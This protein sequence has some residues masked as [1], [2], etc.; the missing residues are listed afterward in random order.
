MSQLN[1][2][3]PQRR[4]V[5]IPPMTSTVST[6]ESDDDDNHDDPTYEPDALFSAEDAEDDWM[7][8]S[9]MDEGESLRESS[10]EEGELDEAE[11]DLDEYMYGVEVRPMAK[12]RIT[13]NGHTNQFHIAKRYTHRIVGKDVARRLNLE[14]G[15]LFHCHAM[16]DRLSTLIIKFLNTLNNESV[17]NM[18]AEEY[19]RQSRMKLTPAQ[20]AA[21][22]TI[23]LKR[24]VAAE[25]FKQDVELYLEKR[26]HE[27]F[28]DASE[29]QDMVDVLFPQNLDDFKKMQPLIEKHQ[30]AVVNI[31]RKCCLCELAGEDTIGQFTISRSCSDKCTGHECN[32]NTNS[33]CFDCISKHYWETTKENSQ[34]PSRAPGLD[35][36]TSVCPTCRAEFCINDIRYATKPRRRTATIRLG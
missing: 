5:Q 6:P 31:P 23:E 24:K 22:R 18:P 9:E 29:P 30:R 35:R 33:Y 19:G 25:K 15:R 20:H 28:E 8:E 1:Q 7:D 14:E 11:E 16:T 32:C 17:S 12:Y 13:R 4:V 34:A 27:F 21:Y 2:R 10:V 36:S 26:L 3:R